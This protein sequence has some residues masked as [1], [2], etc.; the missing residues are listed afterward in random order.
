MISFGGLFAANATGPRSAFLLVN[1][2]VARTD[3]RMG[4]PTDSTGVAVHDV[5]ILDPGDYIEIRVLQQSGGP[6][7]LFGG[8]AGFTNLRVVQ[9]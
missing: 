2:G 6:L 3:S 9:L 8:F 4:T 1:G 5:Q 7:N